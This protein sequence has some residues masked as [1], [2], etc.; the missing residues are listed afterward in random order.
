MRRSFISLWVST[1]LVFLVFH[2]LL[3]TL[4]IYVVTQ[5]QADNT[6]VGLILT[7]FAVA[8]LASR[9]LGGPLMKRFGEKKAFLGSAVLYFASTSLFLFS[10]NF[11]FLL[12]LRALQGFAVGLATSAGGTIAVRLVPKTR[13]GEGLGY[14]VMAINLPMVIGPFLGLTLIQS[15]TFTALFLCCAV[16]SMLAV[17]VGAL[18][19][20]ASPK[21]QAQ[22]AHN[23]DT[24][25]ATLLHRLLEP[26]VIP[27]GLCTFLFAFASAGIMAFASVYGSGLG[28]MH[29]TS[30]F[31]VVHALVIALSRPVLGRLF[32]KVGVNSV[33]YLGIV[34]CTIGLFVLSQAQ[35]V[36]SFLGSGAL[37]GL[38]YGML[39]PT[40]QALAV[41]SVPD[42][43][44]GYAT[45]TFFLFVDSGVAVGSLLLGVVAE[46]ADYH[47]MYLASATVA[48]LTIPL[49]FI[50]H[51]RPAGIRKKND[52]AAAQEEVSPA[53]A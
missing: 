12:A 4:P 1:F 34:A 32:D 50:T 53:E 51:H 29:L 5:F 10:S 52:L 15:L 18:I 44:K 9:P 33:I 41:Q 3:P 11:L 6:Q 30:Y 40:L 47:T 20:V 31:F 42:H 24:S 7:A 17:A 28:L 36:F 38:G 13:L 45:S 35:T 37:V 22:S 49:F 43:R 2:A 46:R 39:F 48:A 27:V 26:S 16:L 23:A 25:P 8:A 14:F 21:A 19:Q